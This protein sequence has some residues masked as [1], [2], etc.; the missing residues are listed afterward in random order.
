MKENG[1]VTVLGKRMCNTC[2]VTCLL[3][4]HICSH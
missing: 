4:S 2:G 3:L 1:L